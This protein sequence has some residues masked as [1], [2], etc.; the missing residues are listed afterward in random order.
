MD[1]RTYVQCLLESEGSRVGG[2]VSTNPDSKMTFVVRITLDVSRDEDEFLTAYAAYKNAL[3]IAQ[4]ERVKRRESRKSV[5][6]QLV[7][8]QIAQTLHQLKAA[9]EAVGELPKVIEG[10]PKETEELFVAYAKK[11]LAWQRKHG[12]K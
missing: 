3:P 8:N 9:F 10:K 7:T 11:V 1:S 5:A 12:G 2:N 4:G 6:E